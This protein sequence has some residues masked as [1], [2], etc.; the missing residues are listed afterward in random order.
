MFLHHDYVFFIVILNNVIF[1]EKG[2]FMKQIAKIAMLCTSLVAMGGLVACQSTSSA[3]QKSEHRMM[4][5]GDQRDEGRGGERGHSGKKHMTEEENAQ[6]EQ[7]RAAFEAQVKQACA[8]KEGQ[9]VKL[10]I[11]NKTVE[12]T[13]EVKFKPVKPEKETTNK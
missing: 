12:G 7:H 1:N 4:K 2:E 3:N 6:H 10:T 8:G 11:D 13:C 9:T 5:H